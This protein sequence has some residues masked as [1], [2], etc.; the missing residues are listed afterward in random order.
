[1]MFWLVVE[2]G[3]ESRGKGFGEGR[4]KTANVPGRRG[5]TAFY[6]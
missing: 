3:H 4:E 2:A 6:E 5:E 1:M